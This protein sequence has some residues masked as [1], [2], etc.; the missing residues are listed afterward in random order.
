MKKLLLSTAVCGLA[1]AAAPAYAEDGGVKLGLGGFYKGY[2]S[3]VDQDE[4][5]DDSTTVGDQSESAHEIDWLQDTE[6]HFTGETTLDNGL[7]VGAHIEAMADG[8]E[9]T[10]QESYAYFSGA[11]G[12]INAGAEDGA[13]YLLQVAAPSADSN[14]DGLRQYINGVNYDV[15]NEADTATATFGSFVGLLLDQNFTAAQVVGESSV[16]GQDVLAITTADT[17]LVGRGYGTF[18]YDN[19]ITG[20]SN[21][22]TYLTPVLNGFQA[23]VS[24]TPDVSYS[25]DSANRFEDEAG[26]GE[27][28][29]GDSYEAAARYEGQFNAVGVTLGAGYAFSDLQE[30]E[31]DLAYRDTND[32]GAINVGTDEVVATTDDRQAWNLGGALTYGPVGFGVTYMNDDMGVDGDAD[33]DT[34]AFGV[35]YTTGP[36]KLGASYY[37]QSQE[38]FSSDEIDTDRYTGGIVYTYGPGMT[39]RGSVSYVEHDS[40]VSYAE[41]AEA[42]SVLLGTQINF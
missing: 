4:T 16:V 10:S 35:D 37:M 24:Y 31:V 39:F 38:V 5:P 13:V 8:G 41:D 33:R 40:P 9:F 22:L 15:M 34:W 11:W 3:F 29:Y 12:R 28:D 25:D 21:K 18:D 19:A 36:F 27:S 20:Y 1:F 14:V 32:N 17:W 2:V 30:A 6:V 23:G 7:T 42:T 26:A